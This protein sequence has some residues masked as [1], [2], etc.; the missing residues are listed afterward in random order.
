MG[1]HNEPGHTRLSPIPPLHDLILQLLELVM[2]TSDPERS[3][4][5]FRNDAASGADEVVL[6]VNN[7]GGLSELELGGIVGTTVKAL[8]AKGV[9]IHRVLAGSFMVYLLNHFFFV[10][11]AE[12]M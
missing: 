12:R 7:L 3:F 10:A 5:P 6:L 2:S 11:V 1:I 8:S 4:L 9:K